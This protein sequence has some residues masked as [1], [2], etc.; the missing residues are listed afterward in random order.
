MIPFEFP[1]A[2]DGQIQGWFPGLSAGRRGGFSMLNTSDSPND[3][4]ACSLS[5]VLEPPDVIPS[6]FFLSARACLGILRR[7]AKRGKELP[8][9]L[10][11][12]LTMASTAIA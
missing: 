5:S 4:A 12:A 3:A 7:A 8:A 2:A 9:A 10:F 6:R 11:R 1:G